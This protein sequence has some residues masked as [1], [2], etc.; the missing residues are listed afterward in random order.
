M[1]AAKNHIDDYYLQINQDSESQTEDSSKKK[2]K[3]KPKI[4]W[5]VESTPL[6]T[7]EIEVK[8]SKL[9]VRLKQD[10]HVVKEE[11]VAP[12]V[13]VPQ[14]DEEEEFIETIEE[15]IIPT[16]SPKTENF[17]KFNDK[18]S[19]P[20]FVQKIE[21]LPKPQNRLTLP[22]SN[23]DVEDTKK[24]FSFRQ[25][26]NTKGVFKAK[27]Q[28]QS[29]DKK[30]SD[31]E[32]KQKKSK[33]SPF[34][35]KRWKGRISFDDEDTTFRRSNK[36]VKKKEEKKVEDIKQNLT[37]RVWETVQIPD[38]LTLKEFSEK[39]GIGLS[40]L[41]A[42]FMK[43]G[44]L[45]NINSKVDFETA[46]II[47]ES[48]EVK[49]ERLR[50]KALSIDDVMNKN[51]Q[52][53]LAEDDSTKLESRPPVI[54][55]MWH[56]DHGKTSLLDYIRQAKVA[57]W[58]AGWITQSIGAYQVVHKN[59]KITF[60]DTPGHEAFTVMRARGARS[61][62]I[63]ILVVA[64][65]EWVKP[66]TI[67]SINHA[68]EAQIPVIVA[69]NK[70]DKEGANPDLVK[71]Q[72]SEHWLVPEEWGWETPFIPVSAKTWFWID[73]LLE[74][75]LLMSEMKN[76]K[77]NPDRLG[78]GTVIESHLDNNLGPVATVLINTGKFHMGDNIVC[79][80]S[81]WKVKILKDHTKKWIKVWN[82]WDPI[83]IIGLSRVVEG[84]DIIQVTSD[85]ETARQKAQEYAEIIS[86][87]KTHSMTWLETIMSR[88]QSWN[89]KQLKI[90][91]KADT[92]GS[93]E[94]IKWALAK[95]S[96]EETQVQV[97]HSWVGNITEGDVIMCQGSSA[98]LIWFRAWMWSNAKLILQDSGVEYISS[99][100][101]YHIT[102]R[103][104]KIVS[105]MLDPKEVE[106]QL[107]KAIVGWIF[108]TS[109]E[110]SVV[111]LKIKDEST[112]ESKAKVRIIRN[113]KMVWHADIMS[114]KQ[115]IEEV[116]K[117]E[118][119]GECGIKIKW[120][121]QIEIGDMLEI[122]KI[123]ILNKR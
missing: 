22:N 16:I 54:S 118:G 103:I 83:L 63:A 59:Q 113:E 109:K 73:D 17:L 34:D 75:I 104:E 51:I 111:G 14:I 38:V 70:M 20:A 28:V 68:K 81:F 72:I 24:P 36:V 35:A 98:I 61:T 41:I 9:K 47:A 84:G 120:N 11:I 50:D 55:I 19:K 25:S 27:P 91:V 110:F 69:V 88:I 29:K 92:N 64:A 56:V 26:D 96:T 8:P 86:Q 112:V 31:E 32:N 18:K 107:W 80:D 117:F 106:V 39:I 4:K 66:Q 65:D 114:L 87:V 21:V 71:S 12:V 23:N 57:S 108:Y 60:L 78:I 105:G 123:Q 46:S 3:L 115:W 90:V 67:E 42:E 33:L 49:T 2:L 76:L 30:W 37:S 43:N 101:I 93:L 6:Q 45:V 10:I 99:E 95:L 13:D 53:L 97:I 116:Q 40:P 100:V 122:Y 77:A 44:M 52:T 48:F 85:S 102:E 121:H 89:L 7:E 119:P 62:D 1:T 94:A 74:V 5:V 79:N 82:P 58:E 15:E